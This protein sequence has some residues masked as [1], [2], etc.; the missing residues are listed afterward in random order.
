MFTP[1]ARMSTHAPRFEKLAMA[2]AVSIAPTEMTD[3]TRLG[4]Y[5]HASARA[6]QACCLPHSQSVNGSNV[7]CSL[8]SVIVA[9]HEVNL[10]MRL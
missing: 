3:D 5:S 6:W 4:L 7:G 9:C 10:P 2:S 8:H 1:G